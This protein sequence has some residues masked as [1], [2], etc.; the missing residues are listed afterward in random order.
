MA[1]RGGFLFRNKRLEVITAIILAIAILNIIPIF[2]LPND[3]Q[4]SLDFSYPTSSINYSLVNTNNSLYWQSH[5]G[6]DGS[7]LTGISLPGNCPAGEIV[8]N[9]TNSGVQCVAMSSGG[10]NPFD[11]SLNTTSNVSFNSINTSALEML[12]G[13]IK[14]SGG[15]GSGGGMIQMDSG[16]IWGDYYQGSPYDYINFQTPYAIEF[17]GYGGIYATKFLTIGK[18][19]SNY[20]THLSSGGLLAHSNIIYMNDGSG[21][22]GGDIFMEGGK[23]HMPSG[24][25][26][27]DD[28]YSGHASIDPYNRYLYASDW[29]TIML[30][31]GTA[32]L[33][34]FGAN[35]LLTV[36]NIN[37]T[38][39]YGDGSGLTGISGGSTTYATGYNNRMPIIGANGQT[40]QETLSLSPLMPN[41]T[42]T[43]IALNNQTGVVIKIAT[44]PTAGGAGYTANDIL[45]ITSGSGDA[46]VKVLTINGTGG[47]L[48]LQIMAVSQGT[49]GYSIGTGKA[50]SGGTGTGCTVSI[51]VVGVP[52]YTVP[53]N[54]KAMYWAGGVGGFDSAIVYPITKISGDTIYRQC[55]ANANT[56]SGGYTVST[57]T[58]FGAGDIM[59]IAVAKTGATSN[60]YAKIITFDSTSPLHSYFTKGLTASTQVIANN[61]GSSVEVGLSG[62][63]LGNIYIGFFAGSVAYS[64][65][66]VYHVPSGGSAGITNVF[67]NSI[68]TGSFTLIDQQVLAPNE[69]I[70]VTIT[71]ADTYALAVVTVVTL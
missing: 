50:T 70:F 5:T 28:D 44:A 29:G 64:S 54:K 16:Q 69:T 43:N 35:N 4:L 67:S 24:S 17:Y 39:F 37:A 34:D 33:A 12:G 55:G 27:N 22:S 6:T 18:Y 25:T 38:K 15:D 47:V 3:A 57:P 31:W 42:L 60:I 65:T 71:P 41:A 45:T 68:S 66:G 1:K 23:I 51:T 7:W 49:S 32:G 10:G 40:T 61:T 36:G 19:G 46:T 20:G 58:V 14:M 21:V 59:G 30:D 26:I 56:V 9:T 11:Q 63:L 62:L 52:L 53:A 8:M 48:T 13:D 2:A